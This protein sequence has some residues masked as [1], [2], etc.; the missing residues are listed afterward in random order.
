MPLDCY[1]RF[2]DPLR[3]YQ[4]KAGNDTHGQAME[5]EEHAKAVVAY[6]VYAQELSLMGL[7]NKVTIVSVRE[8]F[9]GGYSSILATSAIGTAVSLYEAV[10]KK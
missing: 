1:E 2:R 5:N 6:L 3:A 4:A 7:F 10:L 8:D 9:Y